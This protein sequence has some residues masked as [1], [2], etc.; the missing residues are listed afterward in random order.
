ML[1]RSSAS[2]AG[3]GK[4]RT[5][6]LSREK[7]ASVSSS[8][9]Y[10]RLFLIMCLWC[11]KRCESFSHQQIFHMW[12]II[13]ACITK[14]FIAGLVATGACNIWSSFFIHQLSLSEGELW[15]H[16]VKP[17]HTQ[18]FEWG[19]RLKYSILILREVY[20]YQ[21]ENVLFLRKKKNG[22]KRK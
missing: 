12:R 6:K 8:F 13:H 14:D 11:S 3:E 9:N 7:C 2:Y 18:D 5:W 10:P 21:R 17:L 19:F 4:N 16:K 22:C 15:A 1:I 20:K